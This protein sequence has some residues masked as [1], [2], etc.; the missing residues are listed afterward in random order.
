MKIQGGP[1]SG[2]RIIEIAG[3]GPGPLCCALLSD[4]GADIIRIDR[5]EPSGLGI[6]YASV[7]ADVRRRGRYS[8]AIDLK[9]KDGAETLLRLV[10]KADAIVDPLRPGTLERLGLGPSECFARN[11]RLVY[12]RIT[13]WGQYGPL[14]QAAGHDINYIALSGVLDAI[15]P[16]SHPVP[17]LNV[18]GD[19]GGGAMFLAVGILAGILESKKSGQGQVVDA[20]MTEGA[21]YLALGCFGLA[22]VGQWSEK[23]ED[24]YLDGGAHFWRCYE[25]KDNKFVAVGALEGKFYSLLVNSL[26]LDEN[27]LPPRFDRN[28][29][30][31]MCERFAAVFRSKTRDEWCAILEGSDACFAPVLN[32]REAANHPH[33]VARRS[34]EDLNGVVQPSPAPKFSRTPSSIKFEPPVIGGQTNQVLK[35]WGVSDAEISALAQGGAI[36]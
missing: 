33:A 22:S 25:T 35:D 30:P 3:I 27:Q 15:G 21:A 6:D 36:G 12:G 29:W 10:E 5:L 17:P 32:F 14:A 23:R 8:A 13:G 20:A 28:H 16:R 4:M 2:Y 31:E 34:F 18:V 24:N 1:L 7:K 19:M 11:P 26:G 9:H